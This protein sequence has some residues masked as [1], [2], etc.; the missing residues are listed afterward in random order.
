MLISGVAA[1]FLLSSGRERADLVLH[2]VKRETLIQTIVARGEL[3]SEQNYDI[4]NLVN[5]EALC[6]AKT[7]IKVVIEDGK[8][9]K[10]GTLLVKLD[11]SRLQDLLRTQ[12]ITYKK[13]H[14]DYIFAKANLEIVTK[15]G[16]T[17]KETSER[18]VSLAKKA[19]EKYEEGEYP[20]ARSDVNSRIDIARGELEQYRDSAAHADRLVK[21]KFMSASQGRAAELK[22]LGAIKNLEK[23]EGEKK[24]LETFTAPQTIKEL[25]GKYDDAVA[26][27][28]RIVIQAKAEKEQA[29]ND[30]KTKELVYIDA[31]KKYEEIEEEIKKCVIL[32]P[33]E[34]L[35]VYY[36]SQQ[37]RRGSG[38][39]QAIV[40]EGE[41]VYLG[42]KL[43]QIP[44]LT[45][46]LV[47]TSI[48]EALVSKVK[49]G[50]R[51][52]IR[53][54]AFHNNILS[55]VVR[56]VGTV[57]VQQDWFSGDVKVFEA[58]VEVENEIRGLKPG[59]NAEVIIDTGER[60]E[61]AL[62]VP[63]QAVVRVPGQQR[64]GKVYVKT[65]HGI[66]PRDVKVGL[67]NEK[68]VAVIEGLAEG[69]QVVLNVDVLGLDKKSSKDD[70]SDKSDKGKAKDG[71]TTGAK[72]K[73]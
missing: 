61:N 26:T 42:Q 1:S 44:D 71:K 30:L 66:E 25:R 23:I 5:H 51:A 64:E 55:G 14:N 28:E 53:P 67:S 60:V 43:M 17:E 9:V 21:K 11:D 18:A 65:E 29:E 41:Q 2:E 48:H 63:V 22:L 73:R 54:H 13:A 47:K 59:M 33:T 38:G 12:D 15:R 45:K 10:K 40:A 50:Q 27:Y 24:V 57:P 52:T 49:E 6:T 31:K 56:T 68:R 34:G 35:V 72:E 7:N 70:K 39:S 69:E 37:S 3:L 62:T 4:Y 46:M 8:P 19:W 58:I 20:Q 32:S 36:Q 16:T